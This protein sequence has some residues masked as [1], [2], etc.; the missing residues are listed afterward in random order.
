MV[1]KIEFGMFV[2]ANID[3]HCTHSDEERNTRLSPSSSFFVFPS[4]H[5]SLDQCFSNFI[6]PRTT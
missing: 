4:I 5:L 6:R 3:S 2:D 1:L